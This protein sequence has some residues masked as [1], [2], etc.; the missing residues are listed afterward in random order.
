MTRTIA[1]ITGASSGIGAAYARLLADDHDLVLVARRA[2]RLADLAEE[3]RAQGA[4]VEVLPADLATHD[5]IAAVTDRLA[6][7]DVRML[8]SNA[9][10]GGYAPLTDVDPAEID[11]LLTLN[12][13]APIQLVRA[14]LPGM[15]AAGEGAVV[16][17]ASLLAFSAGSTLGGVG[18]ADD[19]PARAPRR[20]LYVA[21][22]TATLGFTRTLAG[23]LA[24]TPVRVQVVCPSIVATEW[25]GGVSRGNPRAML[26]EDVA[27]A[28]LAGLRL[29]E[30]VCVPGLEEQDSA[31]DALLAA[32]AMVMAGGF[33]P[34]PAARYTDQ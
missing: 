33:R 32:E 30:T 16:T 12:A 28:S 2:D 8:I 34:A 31:L 24:D 26:P 21:A 4:S 10:A 9:G 3:L 23:E 29:G 7:G 25:N 14:A 18:G 13:V 5:G 22:K 1:L 19:A 17:V 27:S 20:T 15:L 11:R 6:A